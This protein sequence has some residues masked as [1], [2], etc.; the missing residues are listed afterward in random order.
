MLNHYAII[1]KNSYLI[2]LKDAFSKEAIQYATVGLKIGNIGGTTG[3]DGKYELKTT[4]T[5]DTVVFSCLGYK[6]LHVEI[7][8]LIRNEPNTF[9]LEPIIYDMPEISILPKAVKQTIVLNEVRKKSYPVLYSTSSFIQ[10][11]AR[12]FSTP[13]IDSISA[14]YID[15]VRILTHAS[16]RSSYRLRIYENSNSS[17]QMPGNDLLAEQIIV[18]A[19]T[20]MQLIDLSRYNIKAPRQGFFIAIEWL[21]TDG[22]AD[23]ASTKSWFKY[24]IRSQKVTDLRELMHWTLNYRG[25]W[26]RS[27]WFNLAIEVQLLGKD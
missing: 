10:Q 8:T 24:S 17:K 23:D 25:E 9:L 5:K 27:T 26:R 4:N 18:V 16:N 15:K 7:S 2:F 6:S 11:S 12:F 21:K 22:I 13:Q 3:P 1:S 19:N 14:F 20:G